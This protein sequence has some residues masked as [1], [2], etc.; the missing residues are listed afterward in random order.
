MNN[1]CFKAMLWLLII[2]L[3]GC[4]AP[5]CEFKAASYNIRYN[6]SSDKDTGNEWDKRK[7]SVANLITSHQIDIA[8]TQEG[9]AQQLEDLAKLMPGYAYVCHPYGGAKGDLHN[10]ATFYKTSVFEVLEDGVFWY[11]ETPDTKSIGWD[12][13]DLR[14]C[15]WCKF[16][17]KRSGKTFYLFNSHFYWRNK[18]AKANSGQVLV[19]KVLEIAGNAPVICTGDF[20]SDDKTAQI[21]TIS[22]TLQDAYRITEKT[23]TG[24][25]DTNLGGGNFEGNP[26]NRIDFI[27]V[28]ANIKVLD[29]STLTDKCENGHYPSDHLPIACRINIK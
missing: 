23:P 15:H 8:G 13:T 28:S 18:T 11:S 6:A 3:T 16:R 20:N 2:S 21:K 4:V 24:P 10:C 14:I 25:Y 19:N 1:N 17:E 29:Y 12:A 27:F 22:E 7:T 9:D 5:Q 26:Y